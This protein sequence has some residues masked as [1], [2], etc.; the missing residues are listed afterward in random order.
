MIWVNC[1]SVF[2][3]Y[4]ILPDE[5]LECWRHFVLASR[6]LSKGQITKDDLTIAYTLLHRFCCQYQHI[7]GG[8]AVTPNIHMHCHLLEC[9]RDYGPMNSFWLFSF[10]RYNGI[11]GDRPTNNRSIESQMLKRF[12]SDNANLQLLANA[13][14]TSS[15]IG[16]MFGPVIRDHALDLHHLNTGMYRYLKPFVVR[17]QTLIYYLL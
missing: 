8:D 9:V 10:E 4:N 6:V 12:V 5:Q 14:D 3:L 17:H 1:Y 7:Y 11:L 13:T 15:D 16:Q 2:C